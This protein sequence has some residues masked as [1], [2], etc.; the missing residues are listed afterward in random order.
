MRC[1]FCQSV[2]DQSRSKEH[3][4]PESLGNTEHILPPGWVC[5]GCNNYLSL[6]VEK[7]FLASLHLTEC[8][9][10]MA[11]PNNEHGRDS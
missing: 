3:I 6:K 1:I 9:F 7:P 4:I 5:D 10:K 8:R 11:V 2:S